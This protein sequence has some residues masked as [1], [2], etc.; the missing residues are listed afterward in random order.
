MAISLNKFIPTESDLTKKTAWVDFKGI[1]FK[2]RYIS[3]V[4]LMSIAETC[5]VSSYDV[6]TKGRT[7][8]LDPQPFVKSIAKAIV[9]GWENC[10]LKT[11]SDILPLVDT[12]NVPDEEL[13]E[14]V[15]FT[16]ENL[17]SVVLGAHDLDSFLQ[18][19]AM[20]A[21]LFKSPQAEEL[22]KNSETSQSG[23]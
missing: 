5:M 18:E 8:T 20:D 22:E 19:S 16:E 17:I 1:R 10:T 2:I 12:T 9:L 23:I 14:P 4:T 7:K 15:P 6:K 21:S 11:L 3:R 13:N